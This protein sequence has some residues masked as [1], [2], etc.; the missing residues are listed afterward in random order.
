MHKRNKKLPGDLYKK[1]TRE[2]VIYLGQNVVCSSVTAEGLDA[3][4]YDTDQ[5]MQWGYD[6]EKREVHR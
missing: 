1:H 6:A 4:C 2:L 3:S 5:P